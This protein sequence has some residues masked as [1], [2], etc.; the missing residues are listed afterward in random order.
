MMIRSSLAVLGVILPGWANA[1]P[2]DEVVQGAYLTL[3]PGEVRLEL[4]LTPGAEVADAVLGTLD[5]DGNCTVAE[6]EARAFAEDVLSQSTLTLDG[7]ATDWALEDVI[8]PSL[9]ALASG[10][11]ILK[12]MAAA[13]RSDVPGEHILTYG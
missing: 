10:N 3:A 11:D 6:Q 2:V 12:V 8:V 4:D 9:D 7:D 5:P 13:P 1:H